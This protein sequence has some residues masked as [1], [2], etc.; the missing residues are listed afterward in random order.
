MDSSSGERDWKP[1]GGR[2]QVDAASPDIRRSRRQ[3]HQV[4]RHPSGSARARLTHNDP[5]WSLPN[6]TCQRIRRV[7]RPA[8]SRPEFF[9]PLQ[10]GYLGASI[11]PSRFLFFSR[12]RCFSEEAA[13]IGKYRPSRS[14]ASPAV[15][16]PT[17][18]IKLRISSRSTSPR[19]GSM[20]RAAFSFNASK[21]SADGTETTS[22]G[23][24][25]SRGNVPNSK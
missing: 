7:R 18:F 1:S 10:R 19:T 22:P 12:N 4:W 8:P 9:Q 13:L 11:P 2:G 20:T 23:D 17:T 21:Y 15:E 5:D 25:P 6:R 3:V 24:E 16:T 14:I